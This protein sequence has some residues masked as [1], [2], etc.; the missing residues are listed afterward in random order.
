MHATQPALTSAMR[1]FA[2]TGPQNGLQSR[3]IRRNGEAVVV[4]SRRTN[5]ENWAVVLPQPSSDPLTGSFITSATGVARQ[6]F[7]SEVRVLSPA[8]TA[9]ES[10]AFTRAGYR[11]RSNLHLL[12]LDLERNPTPAR[13][14]LRATVVAT[15]RRH[16]EAAVLRTDLLAFGSGSEMDS[17]ELASAFLAT[18]HSR[19]RVARINGVVA[20]FVLFGRADRRGYLQRLAVHPEAQGRG[21]AR[22]LIADGL[23]WCR[24][25]RVQRVVVNTEHGNDRALG[26]Y[27]S[28]GFTLSATGL[29]VMEH[30]LDTPEL[31]VSNTDSTD[32]AHHTDTPGSTWR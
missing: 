12:V 3:L 23:R 11:V 4:E 30:R 22:L 9:E 29:Q 7:G 18:P 24:H 28:L 13:Q 21:I 10:V 1:P 32:N 17:H 16:D 14:R 31:T 5:G 15:Y 6:L 19:L 2:D 26:L 27:Q 8:L 25:R 20:G